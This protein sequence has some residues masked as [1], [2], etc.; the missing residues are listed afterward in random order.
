MIPIYC[1]STS[2]IRDRRENYYRLPANKEVMRMPDIEKTKE[3]SHDGD[4]AELY[5]AS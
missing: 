3:L 2:D 1:C 5:R 4:A